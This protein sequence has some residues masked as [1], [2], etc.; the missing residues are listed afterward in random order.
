MDTFVRI[1]IIVAVLVAVSRLVRRPAA[2][3]R[4]TLARVATELGF[5]GQ[6]FD[7]LGRPVGAP[8][9][10]APRQPGEAVVAGALTA[11]WGE[12][13]CYHGQ[14][15]GRRVSLDALPRPRYRIAIGAQCRQLPVSLHLFARSPMAGAGGPPKPLPDVPSGDAAF[16]RVVVVSAMDVEAA[17]SLLASP[18]VRD[19]LREIVTGPHD[20]R[21][22]DDWVYVVPFDDDVRE[23]G[24][25]RRLFDEVVRLADRLDDSLG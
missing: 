3:R 12:Q 14:W 6:R 11:A 9:A 4:A 20:P 7:A 21:V 10:G 17:R 15:N 22:L 18:A 8:G 25:A 23:A 1:V 2:A 13:T 5:G 19:T 16:D 24:T